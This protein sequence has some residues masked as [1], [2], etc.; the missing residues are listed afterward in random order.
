MSRLIEMW[1][2]PYVQVGATTGHLES[3][4]AGS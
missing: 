2:T 1:D 4:T 3:S